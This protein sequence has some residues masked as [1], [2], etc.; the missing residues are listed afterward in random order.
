[1][2]RSREEYVHQDLSKFNV[3]FMF[4]ASLL[5]DTSNPFSFDLIR[6]VLLKE[7]QAS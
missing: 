7:K 1:M 6:D 3:Y 5:A 4:S 2:S